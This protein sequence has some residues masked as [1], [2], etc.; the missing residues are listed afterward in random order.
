MG[1][2]DVITTDVNHALDHFRGTSFYEFADV[3]ETYAARVL[4]QPSP[5][6]LL[7]GSKYYY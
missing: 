4:S 6:G 1:R 2:P 3:V 5:A 7:P